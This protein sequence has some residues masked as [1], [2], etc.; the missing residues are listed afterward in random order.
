M[1]ILAIYRHFWPDTTPYARLLRSLLD[2]FAENG[3]KTQV[4]SAQPSYNGNQIPGQPRHEFLDQIEVFR[5][6]LWAEKGKAKLRR[7]I[8]NLLF[9]VQ[10]FYYALRNRH[11][12]DLRLAN[13]H[14]PVLMAAM[15]WLLGSITQR[16]FLLH[17]QDVH[18]EGAGLI[19]DIRSTVVLRTALFVDSRACRAAAA[20]VTLSADMKHTLEQRRPSRYVSVI[21]NF[22][23][24]RR[25]TPGPLPAVFLGSEQRPY[26]VLFAGNMGRY[27]RL[28]LVVDA[29]LI[30]RHLSDIQFI[31]M[32]AGEMVQ[33]LKQKAS[34]IL[35]Q[36]VF[37]VPQ[38]S[39]E[40]AFLCME[41]ADLGVV[42]LAP[43]IASVSYP[44]KV[45]TYLEAGC[46]VLAVCEKESSL[47][48]DIVGT[49]LGVG[50][51]RLDA[52]SVAIAIEEEYRS[53]RCQNPKDRSQ[54]SER[55]ASRFGKTQATDK[56]L[57][58]LDA[59]SLRADVAGLAENTYLR[60]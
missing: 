15:L 46:P 43:N 3:H 17:Y 13:A 50:P 38:Q 48:V 24:E 16:P 21:N 29:A 33:Y 39:V 57:R 4:Y 52:R 41:Q 36:T 10:A 55:A 30:L 32:G 42:S 37:F 2:S 11:E 22:P 40:V 34:P 8:N 6:R 26:R 19:G 20:V 59:I 45:M 51:D 47:W 18:P 25:A 1:R 27:Q 28:D 7:Q 54:L 12:N 44:S 58:L 35:N 14:P 9:L 49:G 60:S 53:A 5:C 31:F 23:L 56:W